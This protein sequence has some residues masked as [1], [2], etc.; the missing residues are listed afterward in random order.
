MSGSCRAI[1]NMCSLNSC[2]Q[3]RYKPRRNSR[4]SGH[5]GN[6]DQKIIQWSDCHLLTLPEACNFLFT[7]GGLKGLYG[8]VRE[9]NNIWETSRKL[10]NFS[11]LFAIPYFFPILSTHP[12]PY[13]NTIKLI[14]TYTIP[15]GGGGE[16]VGPERRRFDSRWCHWNFSLT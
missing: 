13:N 5:L 3:A 14:N 2:W 6:Y 1:T 11:E 7:R 15:F 12:R 9:P 8:T 16:E 10:L 4:D